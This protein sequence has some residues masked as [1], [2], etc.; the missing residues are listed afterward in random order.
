MAIGNLLVPYSAIPTPDT[1]WLGKL[2]STTGDAIDN[3]VAGDLIAQSLSTGQTRGNVPVPTNTAQQPAPQQSQSYAAPVGAVSRGPAQGS[4]YAPFIETVR[5]GGLTNPYGLSAVAAYGKAESGWN[6]ENAN[7]TWNDPSES[8]AAGTSGGILSWRGPRLASLQ[9]YAQS[10]GEQG[11][12]SPQTQAEFFLQENPQVIQALNNAKS[13]QEANAVLANAWKFAGYDR[14]GGENARRA[15]LTQNYYAQEFANAPAPQQSGEFDA[16]RFASGPVAQG[17]EG[18]ATALTGAAQTAQADNAPMPFV[19]QTATGAVDAQPAVSPPVDNQLA[20]PVTPLTRQNTD[21]DLIRRMV[22]NPVTRPLGL[23]LAQQVLGNGKTQEPFQFVQLPNGDLARAN[24]QTGAI[25][26]IGNFAKPDNETTVVGNDLVRKSDGTVV[27]SGNAKAPQIVELFDEQTGQPYKAQY[28][29]STMEYKRV[30]GVK[31]PSGL[32][33]QTNPDGTTTVT[34]GPQ[35]ANPKL[36]EQQSKDLV[37][38]RRGSG[39]LTTLDK[40]SEE[41]TSPVGAIADRVP[42]GNYIKS[43]DYQQA[44]QAGMEFLQAILRKDTGAA[45][46]NAE[47]QEYGKVYLPRPGDSAQVLVQKK[48]ARSR[49]LEAIR[50]GLGPAEILAGERPNEAKTGTK[51]KTSTGVEWSIE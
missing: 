21:P 34:Q 36:T 22:Q 41:L 29:P 42:G 2:V 14:P 46:T 18:L 24:Q 31:A 30:G 17:A 4:T 8:G 12:G 11:N 48:E 40:I 25:E 35:G 47:Q 15:A 23:Q 33:V 26:R 51:N 1:S 49:A 10:K 45:I 39:A 27:Y 38:Y 5:G 37:Y 50:K 28:D 6:G 44:E 9:N 7:R 32:T 19:D 20:A 3:K 13:P 43:A 16:G